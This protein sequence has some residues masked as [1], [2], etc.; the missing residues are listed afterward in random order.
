MVYDVIVVGLGIYGSGVLD[1]LAGRGLRVLG[2]ERFLPPHARGSS[3]GLTR[4]IRQ[5]YFEDPA[6]VPLVLRAY[7]L[8]DE[9]AS[10]AGRPLWV[11]T[12]G[13]MAGP[14]AGPVVAGALASARLHGLAH[15]LL[16]PGDAARRFPQL[17]LR[18]D[19]VALYEPDAGVLAAEPCLQALLARA[20]ERGAAVLTGARV[21]GWEEAGGR[22]RVHSSAGTLEAA[23]LVVAAG[24]WLPRLVPE[25]RPALRVTRQV[26][27]WF[28]ARD[29]EAH[30]PG[31]L[32]VF[33]LDRG[34]EP[35]LYGIPPLAGEGVKVALHHAGPEAD[36]DAG[37]APPAPA[38]LE[39][40][41]AQVR[42]RLPGLEPQPAAVASCFY[43][44]TPDGHFAVGPHPACPRV[45]IV[46]CCSGHGFKFAPAVA[47]AVA[48]AVMGGELRGPLASPAFAVSR[49]WPT[50][51]ASAARG[52][53][54]AQGGVGA[55][56]DGQAP[57]GGQAR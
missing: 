53:Q 8:W 40:V 42:E 20:V 25:L 56:T 16:E 57:G 29:A 35:A 9:L 47:E 43:T 51:S 44:S 27:C 50:G 33:I 14:P 48:E 37:L 10:G 4:I 28:P 17:R 18:P 46:S 13:L 19:E 55:E 54:Q 15:E 39:A 24:P 2:V 11:R 41:A 38:E 45:W 30:A 31:R 1:A 23:R 21:H 32:P 6:Y 26:L 22:V 5:A 36:P 7:V 49:L 34:A 3:H 52:G 12:G